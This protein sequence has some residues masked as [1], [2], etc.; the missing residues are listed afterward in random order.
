MIYDETR[1]TYI[2]DVARRVPPRRIDRGPMDA[3]AWSGTHTLVL[4]PVAQPL[5]LLSLP[6]PVE[7]VRATAEVEVSTPAQ[8]IERTIH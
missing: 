8:A 6:R 3:I 1:S 5:E 7:P 2:V 4:Q